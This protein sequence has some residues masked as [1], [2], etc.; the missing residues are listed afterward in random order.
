MEI[1]IFGCLIIIVML[2]VYNILE[3]IT[4]MYLKK[5]VKEQRELIDDQQKLIKKQELIIKVMEQDNGDK[6][7]VCKSKT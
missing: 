1:K 4:N 6:G 3:G 7:T 5:V 2:G